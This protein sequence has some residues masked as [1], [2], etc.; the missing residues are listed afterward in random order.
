GEGADLALAASRSEHIDVL[1]AETL[2][3]LANGKEWSVA[4]V[5]GSFRMIAM[6]IFNHIRA[7]GDVSFRQ[8]CMKS[9]GDNC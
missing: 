5:L 7:T 4:D 1:V 8:G 2:R 9:A 6:P 3:D